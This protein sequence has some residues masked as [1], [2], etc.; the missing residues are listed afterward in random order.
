MEKAI[1]FRQGVT[2]TLRVELSDETNNLPIDL[3]GATARMQLR[4][5]ANSSAFILELKESNSRI[6]I[7]DDGSLT[8]FVDAIDTLALPVT[9]GVYDLLVTLADETVIA[10]L[11]GTFQVI[12]GVTR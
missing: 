2:W 1:E 9:N 8:L 3:A 12:A 4:V 6:T 5:K 10:A 7:G 11:Y